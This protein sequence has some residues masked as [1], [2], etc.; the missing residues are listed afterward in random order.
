[1]SKGLGVKGNVCTIGAGESGKS[2]IV[3]QMK[4]LH[5]VNNRNEVGFSDE[6]KL[7]A[8][9]AIYGNIMDCM[10]ALIDPV[11]KLK[12]GTSSV[13]N[14]PADHD[15]DDDVVSTGVAVNGR[16]GGETEIDQRA[17][18]ICRGDYLPVLCERE[19]VGFKFPQV[20]AVHFIL[21]VCKLVCTI[22]VTNLTYNA[23]D[24]DK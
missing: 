4:L 6:E 23:D 11:D 8:R 20:T 17:R 5:P 22:M 2:T 18:L 15:D 9:I 13:V 21:F 24:H 10:V 16:D 7:D 14:A 12:I 19:I 1:M 3:K